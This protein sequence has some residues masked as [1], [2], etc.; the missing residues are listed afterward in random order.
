[1]LID[2]KAIKQKLAHQAE[3]Q[4]VLL[5]QQ[6]AQQ[7]A[8]TKA[9]DEADKAPPEPPPVP[10]SPQT[11]AQG[12]LPERRTRPTS[13][14]R[15][16]QYRR[17]EDRELIT[18]AEEEAEWIK[19]QARQQGYQEGLEQASSDFD[20]LRHQLLEWF[21]LLDEMKTTLAKDLLPLAY[22]LAESILKTQATVD[23]DLVLAWA[24]QL[25][26]SVD[27]SQKQVIIKVNPS[28]APALRE[29]MKAMAEDFAMARREV[30]IKGMDE[31][32]T[33]A[34]IL[35]TPAGQIDASLTTQLLAMRKL[36]GLANPIEP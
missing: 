32:D 24:K 23:S 5:K 12:L 6:Q 21:T 9:Q 31:L 17:L 36:L 30:M 4:A 1:M 35:E 14:E 16:L 18:K 8:Q 26:N 20:D 10:Y 13:D 19:E 2:P 33:G 29:A 28:H 27:D 25:L 11:I 22:S 3:A 15:R 7:L 34:C